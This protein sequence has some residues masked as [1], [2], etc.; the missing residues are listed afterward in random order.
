M[1]LRTSNTAII[2]GV[3]SGL[4]DLKEGKFSHYAKFDVSV[5]GAKIPVDYMT[6]EQHYGDIVNGKKVI[7]N[8]YLSHT[9]Y[10]WQKD[11][12]TV[13]EMSGQRLTAKYLHLTPSGIPVPEIN[14]AIASGVIASSYIK[15]KADKSKETINLPVGIFALNAEQDGKKVYYFVMDTS[16]IQQGGQ[17]AGGIRD[18]WTTVAMPLSD[19]DYDLLKGEPFPFMVIGKMGIADFGNYQRMALKG[20]QI[21]SFDAGK[22]FS[23]DEPAVA[24]T[25]AT[26]TEEAPAEDDE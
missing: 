3:V 18:G 26:P 9:W 11:D 21:F 13:V 4:K 24:D 25:E 1:D 2:T 14:S 23:T 5:N 8:G 22:R 10:D 19:E 6:T 12:G 15:T 17:G 20:E 7:V 16:S